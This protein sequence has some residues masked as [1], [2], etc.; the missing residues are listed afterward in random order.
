MAAAVCGWKTALISD[1]SKWPLDWRP[2]ATSGPYSPVLFEAIFPGGVPLSSARKADIAN[3]H[4][5]MHRI[6][7]PEPIEHTFIAGERFFKWGD[8]GIFWM[9]KLQ[10]NSAG[11]SRDQT[12]TLYVDPDGQI[13]FWRKKELYDSE[14]VRKFL[15]STRS[16]PQ[17]VAY[18]FV[19]DIVDVRRGKYA[20]TSQVGWQ[21]FA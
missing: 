15:F 2:A 21:R 13:L 10:N 20:D 6:P 8:V 14:S 4:P 7:R 1:E 16:R 17:N 12:V 5:E 11:S 19:D 3:S 9:K 18:V